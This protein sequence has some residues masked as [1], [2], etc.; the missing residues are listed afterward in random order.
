MFEVLLGNIH[1]GYTIWGE[2]FVL[3]EFTLWILY[4]VIEFY[5]WYILLLVVLTFSYKKNFDEFLR[6][7]RGGRIEWS[8]VFPCFSSSSERRRGGDD[9]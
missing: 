8:D 4:I 6:N 1:A 2:H 5:T 3:F 9:E 7:R